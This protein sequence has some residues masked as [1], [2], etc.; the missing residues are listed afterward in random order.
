MNSVHV[1]QDGQTALD[2]GWAVSGAHFRKTTL[3]LRLLV[4]M[5][6]ILLAA[7]K[8]RVMIGPAPLY[9]IDAI[10]A[11]L[12]LAANQASAVRPMKQLSSLVVVYLV[13]VYIG[14]MRGLMQY[15]KPMESFY[16]IGQSSLAISLFYLIPRLV[17]TSDS[18]ALT[19]KAIVAGLIFTSIITI[20][21][22]LG[23]T[24]PLVVK[25]FFSHNFLVPYGERMAQ[26]MLYMSGE[27]EAL[28][29]QSLIGVSTITTGFLGTMWAFTFLASRWPG[30][31]ANWIKAAHIASM[32]T[33]VAM[34]MTYGRAAW[35]TVLAIGG[36]AFFFGFAKGR[37]NILILAACLAIIV[38][39]VGWR[40]E[41]FMVNR[42]VEKTKLAIDDPYKEESVAQRL[43]SYTQPFSHLMEHPLWLFAGT[44]RVGQKLSQRGNIE[45]ELRDR[46]GLSKHSGFGM[47]Y[48]SYGL[49]A[50]FTHA[51]IIL[52]GLR[53]IVRRLQESTPKDSSLHKITWQT[54]L[55]TWVGLLCWWLPGHAVIGEAR[56]VI[57]FFFFYGFMMSCDRVLSDPANDGLLQ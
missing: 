6:F 11:F 39:Q 10:I 1:K 40:S 35:V 36:I 28:R 50:A 23:S 42:V 13:F 22:S 57:L 47:A 3:P 16:I 53:F 51:L 44:G 56:G 55:M 4:I 25:I 37:R 9:I 2:P 49:L 43:L 45:A 29:G 8:M 5:I 54:F 15:G 48:Y 12:F 52:N 26:E 19:L 7:P 46:A 27:I 17:R 34:L 14:E 32:A 20:L 18:L 33:P 41:L 30:F 21:Y 24:R 38:Y 31:S